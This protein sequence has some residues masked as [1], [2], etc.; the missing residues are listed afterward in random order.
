MEPEEIHEILTTG[1]TANG[2]IVGL[3]GKPVPYR[4]KLLPPGVLNELKIARNRYLAAH[5]IDECTAATAEI[6]AAELQFRVCAEAIRQPDSDEP[7][8][9]LDSWRQHIGSAVRT[10]LDHYTQLEATSSQVPAA[11]NAANIP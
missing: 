8:A 6:Y 9:P 7:L 5:G 10:C 2:E 4:I 11:S 3:L 1:P